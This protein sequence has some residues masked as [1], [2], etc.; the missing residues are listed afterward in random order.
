MIT[1]SA[2]VVCWRQ[3]N[4]PLGDATNAI[5]Q[6]PF[7]QEFRV[8]ECVQQDMPPTSVATAGW[9]AAEFRGALGA[10]N[11]VG[12]TA[13]M[14]DF[15]RHGE[16]MVTLWRKVERSREE[17]RAL[18]WQTA[19]PCCGAVHLGAQARSNANA[20]LTALSL[21]PSPFSPAISHFGCMQCSPGSCHR[22][23]GWGHR[24]TC[25][26]QWAETTA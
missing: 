2:C 19:E 6:W 20:V 15:D 17:S 1:T 7:E 11:V 9:C 24:Q 13:H 16:I 23:W 12:A 10:T 3:C 4:L 25:L 8:H 21:S 18:L 14:L 22:S 26:Q 5:C